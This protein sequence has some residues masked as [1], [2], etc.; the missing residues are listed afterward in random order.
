[1]Y[2]TVCAIEAD[3]ACGDDATGSCGR[4]IGRGIRFGTESR[5]RWVR[6]MKCAKCG[7]ENHDSHK[8]CANCGQR[9][10]GRNVCS[11]CGAALPKKSNF[12]VSCGAKVPGGGIVGQ[13]R[14][15]SRESRGRVRTSRSGGRRFTVV[16]TVAVVIVALAGYFIFVPGAAKSNRSFDD[17][18]PDVERDALWSPDVQRIASRFYCPCGQC[19]EELLNECDC[20]APGGA[21]EARRFIRRLL[22]E[23][24]SEEEIMR[25]FE[26]KYGNKV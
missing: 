25:R 5:I 22:D 16:T 13:G 8:Y 14:T 2:A 17:R 10:G 6:S 20:Q 11:R 15:V 7:T 18:F 21:V 9:L 3:S 1:M 26:A 24:L 12:C 23:N 4:A 19:G